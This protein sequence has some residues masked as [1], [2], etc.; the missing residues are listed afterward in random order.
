MLRVGQMMLAETLKRHWFYDSWLDGRL[1]TQDL[2]EVVSMF[3]DTE[4]HD[5][6]I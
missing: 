6:S 1:S 2:M 3:L 4:S 5:F